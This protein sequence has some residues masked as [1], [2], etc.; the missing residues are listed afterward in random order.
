MILVVGRPQFVVCRFRYSL[1]TGGVCGKLTLDQH[2]SESSLCK[3][4]RSMIRICLVPHLPRISPRLGQALAIRLVGC[5]LSYLSFSCGFVRFVESFIISARHFGQVNKCC[6]KRRAS[7]AM[8]IGPRSMFFKCSS[9]AG[10]MT[11]GFICRV[12]CSIGS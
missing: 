4:R 11:D 12:G 5:R 1:A 6:L 9:S 8:L 10:G 2:D 3:M 7:C